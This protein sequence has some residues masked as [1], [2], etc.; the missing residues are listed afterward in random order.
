M[1]E[2]REEPPSG[3]QMVYRTTYHFLTIDLCMNG[4]SRPFGLCVRACALHHVVVI[5]QCNLY[6]PSD[7]VIK[8]YACEAAW[9]CV[10]QNV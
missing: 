1:H 3:L 2:D 4:C 10:C 5:R 6:A 9:I 8:A 7:L